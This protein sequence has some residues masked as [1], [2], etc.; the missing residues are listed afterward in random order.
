MFNKKI[1]EEKELYL[2]NILLKFPR[3]INV[4]NYLRMCN[5]C[6]GFIILNSI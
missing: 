1:T 4:Q 6:Q 3:I 2:L 5:N